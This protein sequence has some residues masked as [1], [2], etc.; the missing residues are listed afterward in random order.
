M[1]WALIL[2]LMVNTQ[3]PSDSQYVALVRFCNNL[4]SSTLSF[5]QKNIPFFFSQTIFLNHRSK[6]NSDFII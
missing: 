1:Y 3:Q 5:L 6:S 2:T 4:E